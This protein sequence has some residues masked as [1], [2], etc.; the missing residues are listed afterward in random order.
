MNTMLQVWMDDYI[1]FYYE[2]NPSARNV[3]TGDISARVSLRDRLGCQDFKWYLET[4][5]PDLPSP[6]H[7]GG[8]MGDEEFEARKRA[9]LNK[10][11]KK[12]EP[13]DR[14]TRNYLR[15]FMIKLTGTNYCV[16]SLTKVPEKGASL[17][18][19]TCNVRHG[20]HQVGASF[21]RLKLLV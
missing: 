1:E 13:W 18:L 12:F 20:K 6:P 3:D 21:L 14:K 19:R 7:K 5:Y 17:V 4:V 11:S 10:E 15:A 16:E 9:K 2:V 8:P